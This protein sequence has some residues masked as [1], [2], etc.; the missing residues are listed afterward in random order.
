VATFGRRRTVLR[1]G[2]GRETEAGPEIRYGAVPR[3]PAFT[4]NP[5]PVPFVRGMASAR[6]VTGV[7][8]SDY[9]PFVGTRSSRCISIQASS[10]GYLPAA[11]CSFTEFTELRCDERV[12]DPTVC[13]SFI[14]L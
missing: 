14:C 9:D 12:P 1:L 5:N 2:A 8:A 11:N 7:G 10:T 6:S 13:P 3:D 4:R